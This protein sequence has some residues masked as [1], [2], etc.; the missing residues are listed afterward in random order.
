MICERDKIKKEKCIQNQVELIEISYEM[1][2]QIS[3]ENIVSIVNNKLT[4]I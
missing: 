1:D 4:K 3:L 2:V